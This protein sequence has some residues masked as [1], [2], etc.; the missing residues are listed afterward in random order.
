MSDDTH[1]LGLVA[2]KF[3]PAFLQVP[4]AE[5]QKRTCCWSFTCNP[6]MTAFRFSTGFQSSRKMFKHT[7]PSRSILG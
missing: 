1:P 3:F 7:L 5:E 4:E 6:T 2:P